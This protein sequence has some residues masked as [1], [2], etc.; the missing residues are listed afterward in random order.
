M[1]SIRKPL[2]LFLSFVIIVL[3]SVSLSAKG[4]KA[5][6]VT[7]EDLVRDPSKAVGET[8]RLSGNVSHVLYKGNSVR[9]VL[10]FSGKPVV[11]DSDDSGLINRVNV[12]AYVEVCGFYLKNKKLELDGKRTDMPSIVVEQPYCSN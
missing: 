9:F 7:G 2:H 3:Y 10:Q 11:L 5:K 1:N 4:K 8:V 12:G 6:Y